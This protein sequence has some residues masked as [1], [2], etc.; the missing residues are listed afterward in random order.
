MYWFPAKCYSAVLSLIN[1]R[2]NDYVWSSL[3][4]CALTKLEVA[5]LLREDHAEP[6]WCGAGEGLATAKHHLVSEETP[7]QGQLLS[8]RS[9]A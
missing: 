8:K 7:P 5:L 4:L 9:L 6:P 2:E 1:R 3:L